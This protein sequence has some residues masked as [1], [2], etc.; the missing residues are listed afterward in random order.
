MSPTTLLRTLGLLAALLVLWGAFALFRGSLSDAPVALS[1]PA[2][3]VADVDRLTLVGGRDTTRL[4]RE[5]AG[6]WT[7][8]GHLAAADRVVELLDAAH[9]SAVTTELVARSAGSHPRLGVDSAAGRRVRFF[10]GDRVL[11]D[12]VFGNEGGGYQTAYVRRSGEDDVYRLNGRLATLMNRD[13]EGWRDR[14]IAK[15]AA[16]SVA[17]VRVAH[18][19]RGFA[20][21][22][23]GAAWQVDGAPADSAEVARFLGRLADVVAAGFASDAQ[24]D[25]LDFA[26][27]DRRL[28]V[29]GTAGDTLLALAFDSTASG[30]W[31]RRAGGGPVFRLDTWRYG[32]LTQADSTLRRRP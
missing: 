28:V 14:T 32:D 29:T 10:Q 20:L 3:T 21:T 30:V 25:S 18:G 8:N 22:R 5:A 27:P 23:A 7:V 16:D 12:L 6:G 19:A 4:Q 1:L 24:A 15:V 26:R 9:D 31:V 13:A 11:L 17:G 2:L